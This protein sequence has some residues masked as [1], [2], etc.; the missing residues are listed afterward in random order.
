[1]S[2]SHQVYKIVAKIPKGK[3]AT[4]GQI[5]KLS[6]SPLASR[7]VG[8]CMRNNTDTKKVPCHRV[9]GSKGALTGYAYGSGISTKKKLLEQEGVIFKGEKIDLL[10]SLWKM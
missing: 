3:V 4:Y 9:V 8:M 5:A 1:M 6:G 2:F 10:K 7:A